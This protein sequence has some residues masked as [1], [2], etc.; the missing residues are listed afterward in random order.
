MIMLFRESYYSRAGN[1]DDSNAGFRVPTLHFHVVMSRQTYR[2]LSNDGKT[3][4]FSDIDGLIATAIEEAM[5]QARKDVP[6]DDET[7]EDREEREFKELRRLQRKQQRAAVNAAWLDI[8]DQCVLHRRINEVAEATG[9]TIDD[10]TV[11][12]EASDPYRVNTPQNHRIAKWLAEHVPAGRKIHLRGLHYLLVST[13]GLKRPRGRIEL[14]A[15]TPYRNDKSSWMW[16]GTALRA[17]RWL[18]YVPFDQIEDE[19]NA[20][21][22]WSPSVGDPAKAATITIDTP[23]LTELPDLTTLM[24]SIE[25]TWDGTA[26]RQKYNIC[27]L[28]ACRT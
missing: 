12:S 11:G 5:K 25:L 10:L 19:R 2:P 6:P 23:E 17:A 18:R 9:L 21:P 13:P 24:P 4:D 1:L 16:L 3:P 15:K 20:E 27:L 22:E 14:N 8:A 7:S 26:D 28:A